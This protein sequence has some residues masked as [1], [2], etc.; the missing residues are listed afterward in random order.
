MP[1]YLSSGLWCP[2]DDSQA[3]DRGLVP[4]RECDPASTGLSIT[5][6]ARLGK[7]CAEYERLDVA[8]PGA[9]PDL[10]AF[11]SEGLAIA[12]ALQAELP[13]V[14]VWYFD[15]ALHDLGRPRR[16]YMYRV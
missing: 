4:V 8:R 12:Q 1:E 16:D 10:N 15:E 11:A 6:Q 9:A 13:M 5:L 2:R 3:A 7:W 14:E